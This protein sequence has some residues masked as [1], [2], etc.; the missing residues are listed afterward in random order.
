MGTAWKL[1]LIAIIIGGIALARGRRSAAV[2][3]TPT[4]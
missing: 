2:L 3:D 4:E 1:G